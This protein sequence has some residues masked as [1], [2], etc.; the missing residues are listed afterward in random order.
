MARDRLLARSNKRLEKKLATMIVHEKEVGAT[1]PKEKRDILLAKIRKMK[2][3]LNIA[4]NDD[5][6]S[7]PIHIPGM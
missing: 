1:L 5:I 3:H 4:K 2:A 6:K 7:M